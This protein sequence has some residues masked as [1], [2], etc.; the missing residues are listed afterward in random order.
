MKTQH[1]IF[2]VS[3][4]SEIGVLEGVILHTPGLEIEN[5]T[6][7]NAER[8]LYSDVLNLSVASMEYDQ[9]RIVLES[10]TS[11]FQVKKLLEHVMHNS[12]VRSSLIERICRNENAMEILPELE[13]MAEKDLTRCLL[14]GILMKKDNLSR[15]LNNERYSLRPLHNFFFTRDMSVV[16][17]DWVLI[18]RMANKI[19]TREAL[20]MEAIFDYHPMFNVKTLSLQSAQL[21]LD[22]A[23][24]EGGD[25]LVARDDLLIIGI[26]SRTTPEAIDILI[27][28]FKTLKKPQN[29]LVQELPYE[30][31]SFI[32]L[33]MVFTLLD[34]DTCM[35]FEP[36]IMQPNRF[37]TVLIRI[38][39]GKVNIEEE[40]N[41]LSAL[42]KLGMPMNPVNCGGSSDPWIQ[43]RE[44]WHSGA[45]FFA[46]APG[47]LIGYRRNIN[48]IEELDRKGFAIID[49]A[50]VVARKID[51]SK[52]GKCVITIDGSELARGGGGCRCMTM[53]IRRQPLNW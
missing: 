48:T 8:A 17:N 15:F 1:N 39:N 21:Q 25:V 38:D 4:S 16:I 36:V 22:Q 12:K 9:L 50:D 10:T 53:P 7:S 37:K 41:L 35:I 11:V 32:H 40:R 26:G 34:V 43:E 14:E 24:I 3:V 23:H 19:R 47:K 13:G 44:Q 18:S 5:M 52:Y 49:A 51:L 28:H 27:D 31:E 30:P 33:D 46:M 29:I 45:N 2:D 20:I 6:P 42:D